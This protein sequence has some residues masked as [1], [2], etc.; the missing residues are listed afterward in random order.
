[1]LDFLSQFCYT[2]ID[3]LFATFVC[4]W[5]EFIFLIAGVAASV[6]SFFFPF[7]DDSPP[8]TS[9]HNPRVPSAYHRRRRTSHLKLRIF[10]AVSISL[11][12]ILFSSYVFYCN[13]NYSV[14]PNIS[15]FSDSYSDIRKA[16]IE[17]TR[18]K[19]KNI[20]IT[21]IYD[22]AAEEQHLAGSSD[23]NSSFKVCGV[24]V[25][26][27]TVLHVGE[28]VYLYVTWFP[29]SSTPVDSDTEQV[30]AF[31]YSED[32]LYSYNTDSVQIACCP[33]IGTTTCS[34][35]DGQE[36][37]YNQVYSY[38][39]DYPVIVSL[40]EFYS[41][42]VVQVR[43]GTIGESLSFSNLVPGTYFYLTESK[44]FQSLPS[45][46]LFQLSSEASEENSSVNFSAPLVSDSF[47]TL[48]FSDFKVQVRNLDNV[49]LSN[50]D[51]HYCIAS[52]SED[53]NACDRVY[54]AKTDENGFLQ[55]YPSSDVISISC[56]FHLINNYHVYLFSSDFSQFYPINVSGDIGIAIVPS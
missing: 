53:P 49:P 43:I 32:S 46:F 44:N 45:T 17:P 7:P 47:D 1:M 40:V 50:T 11:I 36:I 19:S 41:K 8:P 6:V 34:F 38:D 20:K 29:D 15:F 14:I 42:K 35:S 26:P 22:T 4:G 9:S 2:F 56:I 39:K 30:V 13:Q 28:T 51:F 18:K 33:L 10:L 3:P 55:F 27:G 25:P 31:P 12:A 52:D 24:S 5:N 21:P 48:A 54:H 37:T 23:D 16:I